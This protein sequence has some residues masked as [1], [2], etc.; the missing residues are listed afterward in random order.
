VVTERGQEARASF[1]GFDS[2]SGWPLSIA[3][4]YL[5]WSNAA[6]KKVAAARETAYFVKLP[7]AP[8]PAGTS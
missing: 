4:F 8:G 5:D 2:A 3:G 1:C 6:H 7:I